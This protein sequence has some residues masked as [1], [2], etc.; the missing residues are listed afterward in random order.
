M[1][2]DNLSEIKKLDSGAV[3]KSIELLA[4]QIREVLDEAH[5]IKIPREYSTVKQVVISGMGGSN[6]GAGIVKA[7]FAGEIKVPISILAGYQV[8]AN[9]DKD[10]LFIMSSYS[11]TTEETIATFAEA[12]KRKAKMLIITSG[13]DLEKMM[14]KYDIPGLIFKPSYNPS[15]QPRLGLGYSIFGMSILLA[16]AGLFKIEPKTIRDLIANLELHDRKY[17]PEVRTVNN[18]AKKIAKK[19]QGKSPILV[20]SE[21]TTGNLRV[22]RNQFCETSKNFASY[23][24]IPDMNHYAMEGLSHP[25]TNKDHFIF[26][27]F[28]SKLYHSRVQARN[29]LTKQVVKKNKIEVLSVELTSKT[30]LEQ[31]FEML[32]LGTWITYYLGLLN[33]AHP[34]SVPFVDWFKNEL[35]KIDN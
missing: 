31:S 34:V 27:F 9:V 6:L 20:G 11:G 8:P 22:M 19:I 17:R 1:N 7:V 24:V 29:E 12:K 25:K 21:F 28:N 33:E 13:G 10:T 3:A 14:M 26:V 18:L 4:D 5:L 2:I 30:K 23:L 32:Q 35:H 16:K 15:N